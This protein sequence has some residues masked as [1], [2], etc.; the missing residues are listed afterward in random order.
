M[1]VAVL[2]NDAPARV[3]AQVLSGYGMYLMMATRTD[4]ARS[5]SG[6]ALEA[7]VASGEMLQKCRALLAWGY[8]RA[9]DEA[10]LAALWQARDLAI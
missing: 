8:A 3:R 2:P 4:D 9:D 7:A 5:W 10:G 1:S 6:Q